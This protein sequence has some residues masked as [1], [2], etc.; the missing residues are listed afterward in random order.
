MCGYC[1][2]TQTTRGGRSSSG[3]V[4]NRLILERGGVP[5]LVSRKVKIAGKAARVVSLGYFSTTPGDCALVC[6]FYILGVGPGVGA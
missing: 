4:S 3:R 6:R 5:V 2:S 1:V